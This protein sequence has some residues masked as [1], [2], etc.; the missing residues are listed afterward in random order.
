ME[1]LKD[2]KNGIIVSSWDI[3][4]LDIGYWGGAITAWHDIYD[5][6]TQK[7]EKFKG[8]NHGP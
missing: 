8:E 4:Y 7:F 1:V 5:K 6:L 2:L 3:C